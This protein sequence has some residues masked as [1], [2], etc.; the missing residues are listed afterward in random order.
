MSVTV[1][2]PGTVP[3]VEQR[4][5]RLWSPA[6]VVALVLGV[7]AIF[8]GVLALAR[9]GLD[10]SHL[11]RSHE[12][13]LGFGHTPLLG[14]AE[15]G[16]GWL[17]VFAA[18][19]PIVGRSVMTLVGAAM[20]GLGVAIVGGWWSATMLTWLGAGDRNGW[21]FVAVGGLVLLA[22]FFAPVFTAGG[23]RVVQRPAPGEPAPG[24]PAPDEP[25][26]GE[27]TSEPPS[28]LTDAGE[29]TGPPTGG[30]QTEPAEPSAIDAPRA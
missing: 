23:P 28:P 27:P 13:A 14:L 6:Q 24:E 19:F 3:V 12:T 9:T 7:A 20:L 16:A 1:E 8:F 26:P 25:A 2:Q 30:E 5:I 21:L 4:P 17:L 22:S 29:P 18:V 15:V 10:F 11:T